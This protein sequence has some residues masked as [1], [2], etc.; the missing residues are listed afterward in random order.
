MSTDGRQPSSFDVARR[1]NVSR[2]TVSYVLNGRQDLPIP[3]ETRDRVLRAAADLGYRQNH[4][5]RSLR[6]GKTQTLGVVL[7]GLDEPYLAEIV[8]GIE[9]ESARQGFR[10]LLAN[11]QRDPATEARQVRLLLEH[12]VD[13]LICL[14]S[15]HTLPQMS[16]W[17]ATVRESDLACV[18]AD[19][20]TFSGH[21]DCVVSD[22]VA[23]ARSAVGHLIG[24]GRRRVAHL[25]GGQ[26][27]SSG[28]D[29][30]AGYQSALA[31]AGLDAD[32]AL[33]SDDS[34]DPARVAPAVATLL[35]LP[36]PP[37]ALFAANDVLAAEALEAL[38]GHGR[39]VPEDVALVGFG[40]MSWGRYLRLAT[41]DQDTQALGREAARRLFARLCDPHLP[42]TRMTLSTRLVVRETAA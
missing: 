41:V 28:R 18:I 39:R 22:D 9:T 20:C 17:L 12:R 29:R 14:P 4:L 16:S 30:L 21:W 7:P 40:N 3:Q 35:A 1:A 6:S 38:R 10:V 11:S 2:T 36:R 15:E 26:S 8:H 32:P 42:P 5:A 34:Y 27:V 13:G 33:V 23:G 25:A 31:D 24:L 19:D 37:D